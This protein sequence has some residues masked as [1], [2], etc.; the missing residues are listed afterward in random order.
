MLDDFS[1]M[2]SCIEKAMSSMREDIDSLKEDHE[3]DRRA[4]YFQRVSSK[5][6][7]PMNVDDKITTGV[8]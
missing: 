4:K 6:L 8:S 2:L 1:P 7:A 3:C 5:L